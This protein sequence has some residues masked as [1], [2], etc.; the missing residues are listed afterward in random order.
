MAIE[1]APPIAILTTAG[2]NGFLLLLMGI[3]PAVVIGAICGSVFYYMRNNR[4][5]MGER[6][7]LTCISAITG[8]FS[9]DMLVGMADHYLSVK[10]SVGFSALITSALAILLLDTAPKYIKKLLEKKDDN[11]D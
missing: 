2:T 9:Y 7:M 10:M 4:V 11:V 5:Q 3:P 8:V 6:I 1:T